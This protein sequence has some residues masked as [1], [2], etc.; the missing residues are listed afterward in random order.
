[1]KFASKEIISLGIACNPRV[2]EGESCM[3]NGC[4]DIENRPGAILKDFGHEK[5]QETVE[6][7]FCMM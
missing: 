4:L 6:L 7:K 1:M 3:R 2:C 5:L